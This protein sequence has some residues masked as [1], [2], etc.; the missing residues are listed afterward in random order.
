MESY[1][2]RVERVEVVETGTGTESHSSASK[3]RASEQRL[4]LVGV[5]ESWYAWASCFVRG[6]LT[7]SRGAQGPDRVNLPVPEMC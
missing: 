1:S 6:L 7:R 4:K 2:P 5:I 3:V